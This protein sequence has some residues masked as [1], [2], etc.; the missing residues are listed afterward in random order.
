MGKWGRGGEGA[1]GGGTIRFG[2][3]VFGK[4]EGRGERG[5]DDGMALRGVGL[6]NCILHFAFLREWVLHV[7]DGNE[8]MYPFL[9]K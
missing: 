4:V 5:F 9:T 8:L 2:G 3:S 7:S 1:V 6:S